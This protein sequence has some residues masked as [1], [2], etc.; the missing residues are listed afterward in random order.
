M[1]NRYLGFSLLLQM[2]NYSYAV[3]SLLDLLWRRVSS[4]KRQ[5]GL[6]LCD[7]GDRQDQMVGG[8][9]LLLAVNP[10]VSLTASAVSTPPAAVLIAR[11]RNSWTAYNRKVPSHLHTARLPLLRFCLTDGSCDTSLV[12]LQRLP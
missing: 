2:Y 7:V 11:P 8:C 4:P 12:A 1:S 9:K 3:R 6:P 10:R 5:Y